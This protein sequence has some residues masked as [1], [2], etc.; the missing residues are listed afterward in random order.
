MR[1][2]HFLPLNPVPAAHPANLGTASEP[3]GAVQRFPTRYPV[4]GPETGCASA[5]AAHAARAKPAGHRDGRCGRK[6]WH[7][8]TRS[9]C[10]RP[11]LR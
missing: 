8:P 6:T 2:R 4:G 10:N 7:C 3:E 9:A 5:H 11:A 1:R